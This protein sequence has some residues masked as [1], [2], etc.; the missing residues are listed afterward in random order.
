MANRTLFGVP[1]EIYYVTSGNAYTADITGKITNVRESDVP[2]LVRQGLLVR[3]TAQR[4]APTVRT[5]T[6]TTDKIQA[7]DAGG[8]VRYTSGSAVTVT[9]PAGLGAGFSTVIMQRGAGKV[10]VQG[11]GK[12]AVTNRQSQLG[13]GGNGAVC[14]LFADAVDTFLFAGDTA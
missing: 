14:S 5:V 6:G 13:T 7:S 3:D 8:A 9:I 2:D 12:T 4:V 1:V 11:D 10:T